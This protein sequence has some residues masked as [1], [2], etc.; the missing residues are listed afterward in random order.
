MTTIEELPMTPYSA[1]LYRI[2]VDGRLE[3]YADYCLVKHRI[4]TL[5]ERG[6]RGATYIGEAA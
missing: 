1:G 3:Q 6:A 5:M 4:D 2:M